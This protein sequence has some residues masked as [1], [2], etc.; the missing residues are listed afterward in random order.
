MKIVING[1]FLEQRI[2]GITRYALNILLF[3]DNE[4]DSEDNFE[5]VCSQKT[6]I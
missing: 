3:L 4:I 5:L 6:N 1:R 2:Q